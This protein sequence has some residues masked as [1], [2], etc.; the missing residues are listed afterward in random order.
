MSG[1][2]RKGA[3]PAT[4][5]M[6][7]LAF[8]VVPRF[9]L[10]ATQLSVYEKKVREG[11][12]S[13]ANV[14]DIERNA[15][16]DYIVLI[17]EDA[18]SGAAVSRDVFGGKPLPRN[19]TVLNHLW[20]QMSLA[21]ERAADKG[22]Y[23][24]SF[25]AP[26]QPPAKAA[27][28][29]ASPASAAASR[30][31][32]AAA[33]PANGPRIATLGSAGPPPAAATSN[34][35]GG[36]KGWLASKAPASA[37][38]AAA[39]I[40]SAAAAIA[41]SG[42]SSGGAAGGYAWERLPFPTA[43]PLDTGVGVVPVPPCFLP[44]PARFS[45]RP[46]SSNGG[47]G[48]GSGGGSA[49]GLPSLAVPRGEWQCSTAG[50]W[51][52]P[53]LQ[54][55]AADE[56]GAARAAAA[57]AAATAAYQS[58]LA[59][60]GGG[61][62]SSAPSLPRDVASR[63][64]AFANMS[65]ATLGECWWWSSPPPAAGAASSAGSGGGAG[66][67]LGSGG[68]TAASSSRGLLPVRVA[69]F[70][71]DDTLICSAGS[72]KFCNSP[73]DWREAFPGVFAYLRALAAD[74]FSLV[75]FTNQAGVGSGRTT[76]AIVQARIANVAAAIGAPITFYAATTSGGTFYRKPFPGM[77]WLHAILGEGVGGEPSRNKLGG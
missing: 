72:S 26:S 63:R 73:S 62:S 42:G 36:V 59:G 64:A 47:G 6:T 49:S 69:A 2:K 41:F 34:F 58:I 19:A 55:A 67:T 43:G 27:K 48:S 8:V 4:T 11:G 57:A 65:P 50:R 40:A 32:S 75:V 15:A 44:P 12:G 54:L 52:T 70:D 53:F 76:L 77:W 16:T 24:F 13:I 25:S 68:G 33:A 28:A 18:A 20:M 14:V 7:G 1:A 51:R 39:P 21:D 60:G 61:N 56:E 3:P 23:T 35:G 9:G 22:P 46:S 45:S 30:A 31:P 5:F 37:A 17:G 38:S 66:C 71:L 29:G 74:G 10:L